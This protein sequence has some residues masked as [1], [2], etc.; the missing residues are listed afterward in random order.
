MQRFCTPRRLGAFGCALLLVTLT[1]CYGVFPQSGSGTGFAYLTDVRAADNGTFDRVV[2]EFA[3]G[4]LPDWDVRLAAPPFTQ[5]GSGAPVAV[6]GHAYLTV[7]LGH[8][9]AHT[10]YSGPLR[11]SPAGTPNVTEV[12]NTGDFEGVVNWVIGLN[13]LR[14]FQVTVLD[15]PKRLVIDVQH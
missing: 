6:N 11:F 13:D 9:D 15:A 14:N 7:R 12:V 4:Q 10:Y 8:A 3:A 2:F 1:G 5:D